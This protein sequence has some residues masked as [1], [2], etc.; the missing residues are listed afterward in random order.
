MAEEPL[1]T[2]EKGPFTVEVG[3]GWRG[4]RIPL[5]L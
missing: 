5:S 1:D 4:G 3:W 2:L